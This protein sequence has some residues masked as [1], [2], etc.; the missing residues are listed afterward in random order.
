M[1][2]S[3]TGNHLRQTIASIVDAT[4][5]TIKIQKLDDQVRVNQTIICQQGYNFVISGRHERFFLKK[6]AVAFA[7]CLESKKPDVA[8]KIK[9]LDFIYQKL[10]ED[11][12]NYKAIYANTRDEI[13]RITMINRLSESS[14][15][16]YA[17]KHQLTQALKSIKIA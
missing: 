6:S 13:K 5:S 3:H 1:T 10:T 4:E 9:H 14:P 15:N 17:V 11:T 7:I 2:I 12:T 16:L 8:Q